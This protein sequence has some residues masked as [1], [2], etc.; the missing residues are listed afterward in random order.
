[1]QAQDLADPVV[2]PLVVPVE[3]GEAPDVDRGQVQARLPLGDPLG[4]RPPGSARGCDADGVEAGPDEEVP[5]LRCLAEDELVV[6]GEALRAVVEHLD[7]G[8]GQRRDPLYRTVHQDLEV[9][10]VFVEQLELEGVGQRVGRDPRLGLGLEAADG[11]AA[12]LLLDVGVA[13][14]VAQHG[15]VPVHPVDPFGD[16]VEVLGR[17]QRDGHPAHRA[18]LLG[19][20]AGAVDDHLGLDIAVV[21]ADPCHG[22][23]LGENAGHA[24]SLCYRDAAVAGAPGQ[25]GGQVRRVGPA[26][27]GQPDRPGEVVDPHDRVEL[28]GPFGA[29]QLA[30]Q[31]VSLGG[32]GGPP[33]LRHPVGRPGDGDAAA[34]SEAGGQASLLLEPGVQLGGV[35]HQPGAVLRGA[36]LADQAGRVPGG[37]AR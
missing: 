24:R 34:P 16:H 12:H 3:A 25:R 1:M 8:L 17:V 33:E 31:L 2:Q 30:F 9:V 11:Q 14:G 21:G 37:A 35:L 27:T 15:Q 4:Q 28:A 10:P 19:P 5:Q 20:L 6:R 29:D 22:F 7:P 13:V 23:A 32:R 36:Q 26:V 18:D